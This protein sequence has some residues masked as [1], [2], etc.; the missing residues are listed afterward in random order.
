MTSPSGEA[1]VRAI[2]GIVCYILAAAWFAVL[3]TSRS[4]PGLVPMAAGRWSSS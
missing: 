2:A 4:L 1:L 3:G